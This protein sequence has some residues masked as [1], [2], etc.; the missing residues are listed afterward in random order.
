VKVDVIQTGRSRIGWTVG[1]AIEILTIETVASLIEEIGRETVVAVE[2]RIP[3]HGAV[4]AISLVKK[5]LLRTSFLMTEKVDGVRTL[6]AA[7]TVQEESPT[8]AILETVQE[9]RGHKRM[10]RVPPLIIKIGL[11]LLPMRDMGTILS[12]LTRKS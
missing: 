7:E 3:L 10:M 5:P 8:T 6:K 11:M 2:D 12:C 1:K 9:L 4:V